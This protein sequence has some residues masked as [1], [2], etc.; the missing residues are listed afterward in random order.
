MIRILTNKDIRKHFHQSQKINATALTVS[1][2]IVGGKV[3]VP[4][5]VRHF[6][7]L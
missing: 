6:P 2:G 1:C 4:L 3:P 7:H 5:L